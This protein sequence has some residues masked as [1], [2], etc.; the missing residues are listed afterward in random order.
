M[1]LSQ[2]IINKLREVS[3]K[4]TAVMGQLAAGNADGD[5]VLAAR[6]SAL[7]F[8][9]FAP[10][11][12]ILPAFKRAVA[13]MI[14]G[15]AEILERLLAKSATVPRADVLENCYCAVQMLKLA[16]PTIDQIIRADPSISQVTFSRNSTKFFDWN[17]RSSIDRLIVSIVCQLNKL[18]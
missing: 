13:A 15:I 14:F 8:A 10:K 4:C 18:S 16:G 17:C 9:D 6:N 3:E 2:S 12:M 1:T 5:S 7:F 11:V